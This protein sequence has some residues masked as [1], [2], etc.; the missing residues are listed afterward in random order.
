M[1]GRTLVGIMLLC[2]LAVPLIV[3]FTSFAVGRI[4]LD[5]PS[6][7]PALAEA[8]KIISELEGHKKIGVQA[9]SLPEGMPDIVVSVS[10]LP[11]SMEVFPGGTVKAKVS[12]ATS[13]MVE[14]EIVL[15]Y[16]ITGMDKSIIYSEYEARN[17]TGNLSFIEEMEV[18]EGAAPDAYLVSISL[19]YGNREISTAYAPF[20]VKEREIIIPVI[21]KKADRAYIAALG[22]VA[23]FFAVA[24]IFLMLR[25][26]RMR[27]SKR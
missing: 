13:D 4:S 21:S 23:G 19:F 17:V 27:L 7:E 15:G 24:A 26:Y 25:L 12:I 1:D 2:V 18:P 9:E 5:V 8:E 22:A 20:L 14:R 16:L 10:I 6:R 11:D 3:A